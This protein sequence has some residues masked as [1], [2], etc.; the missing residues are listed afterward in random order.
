MERV[1]N[2][3]RQGIVMWLNSVIQEPDKFHSGENPPKTNVGE[4]T[5]SN[6]HI[7]VTIMTTTTTTMT[8]MMTTIIYITYIF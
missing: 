4:H 3:G 5:I 7:L 8:T 2:V 6:E 1:I